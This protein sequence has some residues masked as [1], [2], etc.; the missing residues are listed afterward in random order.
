MLAPLLLVPVLLAVCQWRLEQLDRDWPRAREQRVSSASGRLADELK[1]ARLLADGLARQATEVASLP[2]ESG[3]A[4]TA[5]IV[6]GAEL[7]A[8]VAVFEADGTLRTWAGRFRLAPQAAGDSVSVR[9]TPFYAVLEVRRHADSGR[10]GLGA[11]LLSAH[12]AVPDPDRSLAARF[13]ERMEVGLEIV[14]P[15]VAPNS[16]DV[17]DYEQ[18][19]ASGNKV[20]FSA[21]LV[22][23]EQ[24]EARARAVR[25]GRALVGWALLAALVGALW[26]ISAGAVRLLVALLAPALALWAPLGAMLGLSETAAAPVFSSTILGPLSASPGPLAL[27]GAV[28]LGFG[29]FLF[30]RP[31]PSRLLGRIVGGGMLLGAPYLLAELGRGIVPPASGVSMGLWLVW[32]VTLFLVS[33]GLIT[34]AVALFRGPNRSA[35]W[36]AP[37]TA[38]LFSLVAAGVGMWVW[39]A[40]YGWPDWYTLLWVPAL[41]LLAVP[42]GRRATI[43]ATAVVAGS[44]AALLAWG[45]A[46]EGR[47]DAARADMAALGDGSAA[48]VD[49]ALRGFGEML[50]TAPRPGALPE[51]Y[52]LWEG[53]EFAW[54][55]RP[56]VLGVWRPDGTPVLELPLATLDVPADLVA[57]MVRSLPADSAVSVRALH[58]EP[59]VHELLLVRRDSSTLISVALGPRSALVPPSRLGRLLDVNPPNTP[60]YRLTIAPAP[61][62]KPPQTGQALWRREGWVAR[63]ERSVMVA[64]IARDVFGQVDLGTPSGLAVRGALVVALDVVILAALW[65]LAAGLGGLGPPRPA[66]RPRLDSYQARLGAALAIFFLAPTISFAAWGLGRLRAEVRDSRDRMIEQSLR[67][68]VPAG[69]A[70]PAGEPALGPEL[71]AL[72]SRADADLVLYRDGQHLAGSTDG[73]LEALGLVSPVMDAEAYHR[74]AIDGE[75]AAA[76]DGPSRAVA[77]RIGFRAV[78]LSDLGAGILAM[79]QVAADPLLDDRQRDLVLLLLLATLT[80]V[81]A[82]LLAARVAARVLARPVAELREAALAF[83]RGDASSTPAEQPP[84]EFA[85]VFSAFEKMTEDVRRA[86]D[87]QERVARIVAWGEMATQVA[88]EIKNPLTPMRLGIQHLRRVY[89]DGRT[90]IGPVLLETTRRILSEID[91]LDR[92]ARS[93][94]RFGTPASDRGPLEAVRLPRVVREVAE[95]YRLGPEGAEIVV[96]ADEEVPVQARSDE[97]KEAI[98]NLLENSRNAEARVIRIRISATSLSVEDD[99]RGIPAQLL[100]MIFEPRFS[101]STSG[102]G[103]GLPIVKRLVE[104]WGGKVTVESQE[105]KG[106]AVRLVLLPAPQTGPGPA[107]PRDEEAGR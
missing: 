62:N 73:L 95:L 107:D 80:G 82:A 92:I 90:P 98:V 67:D 64:G 102:S 7:E 36:T 11:V 76:S 22:P 91:R 71:R 8:G 13:R 21:Q 70:L 16:S 51:L 66:W 106:T 20:L 46:L 33:A 29:A 28:L 83:G 68:A 19:T 52:A 10:I 75:A 41:A 48:Q 63:G 27:L 23:P 50:L 47:L 81:G 56:A 97:V 103:L 99:G 55:G 69:R 100:P 84:A 87:A 65:W 101:T 25:Q 61:S 6:R 3:F 42:A 89:H 85:P 57:A 14:A 12:P 9:L 104:G 86:R 39:N 44:A 24:A 40:R 31:M 17:F 49:P 78:R 34:T 43:V 18:P 37:L 53:S 54:L 94:S 15:Q 1:N 35:G 77:S 79:P 45:A 30:E 58:R 88:H 96:D 93:F 105:G 59:A 32:H 4:T 60:L 5:D 72:G 26:F 2:R 74:I 38:A